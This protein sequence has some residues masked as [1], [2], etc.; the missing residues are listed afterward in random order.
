[1]VRRRIVGKLA[2]AVTAGLISSGVIAAQAAPGDDRAETG[3]S[4]PRGPGQYTEIRILPHEFDEFCDEL[5]LDEEQRQLAA[6]FFEF[7]Q[8]DLAGLDARINDVILRAARESNNEDA[9]DKLHKMPFERQWEVRTDR[10]RVMRSVRN[11]SL[12]L[13]ERVVGEVAAL[14]RE[15]QVS[16]LSDARLALRRAVALNLFGNVQGPATTA[17][18]GANIDLLALV[19]AASKPEGELTTLFGSPTDEH[20]EL[21]ERATVICRTYAERLDALLIPGEFE[22]MD[23]F[24]EMGDRARDGDREAVARLDE[25]ND[26]HRRSIRDLNYSTAR[27]IEALLLEL[28]VGQEAEQWI[29]RVEAAHYPETC[30]EDQIDRF[31]A[32]LE[33]QD[34][35]DEAELIALEREI[36]VFLPARAALREESKRLLALLEE[37]TIVGPGLFEHPR[38]NELVENMGAREALVNETLSRL[39][40]IQNR[41]RGKEKP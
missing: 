20:I 30:R 25:K 6:A 40:A 8:A 23:T 17:D 16:S 27:Q 35:T 21:Q 4:R 12:E 39:H 5:A 9:I 41:H 10:L 29:A 22:Y 11:E 18:L 7:Y 34:D 36:A 19:E 31:A 38:F 13:M 33:K 3:D 15:E 14:L 1:M 24:F 37:E 26:R 28:G 2:I 32:W